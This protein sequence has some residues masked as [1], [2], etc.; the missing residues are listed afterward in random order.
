MF[1]DFGHLELFLS[2][3]ANVQLWMSDGLT[4]N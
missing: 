3:M 4:G 1:T 2:S